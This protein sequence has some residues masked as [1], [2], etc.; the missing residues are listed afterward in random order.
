MRARP[1]TQLPI[2]RD[3]QKFIFE[4]IRAK[5]GNMVIH[6]FTYSLI[7]LN[8]GFAVLGFIYTAIPITIQ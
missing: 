5:G 2:E 3:D 7:R 1:A 4:P 6:I 8:I